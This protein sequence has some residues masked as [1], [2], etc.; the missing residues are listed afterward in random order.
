MIVSFLQG[1]Q[2]PRELSKVNLGKTLLNFLCFYGN[3]DHETTG[4]STNPPGKMGEKPN[5]YPLMNVNTYF[6]YLI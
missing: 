3:F 5:H 2:I 1:H 4:I 6:H